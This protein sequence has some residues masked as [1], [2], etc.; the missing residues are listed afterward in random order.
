MIC[1][2]LV[3]SK[4]NICKI[5]NCKNCGKRRLLRDNFHMKFCSNKCYIDFSKNNPTHKNK[6]KFCLSEFVSDNYKKCVCS[7]CLS[8]FVYCRTCQKQMKMY[9]RWRGIWRKFDYCCQSCCQT[10]K[11][12]P[13]QAGPLSHRWMGGVTSGRRDRMNKLEYKIFKRTVLKRDGNKCVLCGAK[14]S[15]S[16]YHTLKIEVDHIKPVC[17]FPELELDVK[18]ARSLCQ[19]CHRKTPTYGA[20]IRRFKKEDFELNLN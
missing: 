2:D 9:R 12:M 15:R 16:K 14:S 19:S 10:N 13:S 3:K 5:Q 1:L 6:C 11:P 8:I 4:K 7:K 20:R 17:F 18:N